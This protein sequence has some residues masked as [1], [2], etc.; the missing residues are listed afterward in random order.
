MFHVSGSIRVSG[1]VPRTI[2]V[3]LNQKEGGAEV[4]EDGDV[5]TV[6]SKVENLPVVYFEGALTPE[7][8][9]GAAA[10]A[11]PESSGM[12]APVGY[13]RIPYTFRQGDTLGNA[14]VSIRKS[15]S[16]DANL[17]GGFLV[18]VGLPEPMPVDLSALLQGNGPADFL[19]R[20]FDRII[21]P[22]AQF[23]VS[24]FGDVTKRGTTL[25]PLQRVPLLCGPSRLRGHRGNPEEHR[26]HGRPGEKVA[27]RSLH[28]ARKQDIPYGL[29]G[30]SP[31]SRSQPRKFPYRSDYTVADY[32][33]EAGFNPEESTNGKVEV[34]D[35]KGGPAQARRFPAAR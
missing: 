4:L 17:A 22:S 31:G 7:A 25:C 6:P 11:T 23:S 32:E 14:L 8:P 28:R 21:V 33:N 26:H 34:F 30:D 5:V 2:Y 24:V 16:A 15:F 1:D 13:N 9:P 19:L 3:T 12:F 18:R 35:S 20:P 27:R 10:A 29:Q